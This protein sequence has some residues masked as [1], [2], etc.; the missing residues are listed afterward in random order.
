M[1][2]IKVKDDKSIKD[3]DY[4]IS[5]LTD[6][7]DLMKVIYKP[8]IGS[9]TILLELKDLNY[10]KNVLNSKERYNHLNLI[11]IVSDHMLKKIKLSMPDIIKSEDKSIFEYLQEG[12]TKRNLLIN[13]KVLYMIYSS[14]GKSYEEIDEVLDL[15]YSNFGSY[16]SISPKDLSQYIVINNI[17]YP[18]SVLIDYINLNRYRKQRLQ[19]CLNDISKEIVLASMVKNI[20]KLHEQKAKYLS[21]G[22]GNKFI[23][24]LNTRN[25]NLLYNILVCS[26]PY[27]LNS[28][29]VLLE[30]YERGLDLNDLLQ[31]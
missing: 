19:K 28:I 17:T 3:Y 30:I 10:I 8:I 21:T 29:E 31:S 1:L 27:Y 22:I 16:M 24:N 23:R 6:L 26:K 14:V 18:R 20:K 15:L 25:L 13:K 7:E 5:S 12:I 9:Y 2:N 4:Y 11:L